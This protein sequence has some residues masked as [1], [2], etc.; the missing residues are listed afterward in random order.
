MPWPLVQPPASRVPKPMKSPPTNIHASLP[1]GPK[2]ITWSNMPRSQ[3]GA[4]PPPSTAERNPPRT[5]PA[6]NGSRHW[7]PE[8]T[9]SRRKYGSAAARS[10]RRP[11]SPVE[12]PRRRLA[13]KRRRSVIAAMPAP[14][15]AQWIGVRS[16]KDQRH[17]RSNPK[18]Q[19]PNPKGDRTQLGVQSWDLGLGIWVLGFTYATPRTESRRSSTRRSSGRALPPRRPRAPHPT[20]RPATA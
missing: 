4:H 12:M 7:R 15:T 6:R 19:V 13:T 16:V 8:R 5:R 9:A 10:C 20:C 14:A 18:S 3:V 1:A 2:P 17:P 11:R